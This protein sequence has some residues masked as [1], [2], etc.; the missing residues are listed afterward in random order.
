MKTIFVDTSAWL[1]LINKSDYLH[2]KARKVRDDLIAQGS[3]LLVTDY[4]LV[5]TANALSRVPFRK[6]VVELISFIQSSEDIQVI[7]IDKRLFDEAWRLYSDRLDKEWSLTDCASF[8]VM[9]EVGL[10]EAFTSD[11][12]FEQSGFNIL[13]GL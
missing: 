9:T 6:A 3:R 7:Q 11:H 4:V 1:A 5:E 8:V 13:M 2:H 10:R 12:H